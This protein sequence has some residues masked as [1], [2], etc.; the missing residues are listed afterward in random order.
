[1][2]NGKLWLDNFLHLLPRSIVFFLKVVLPPLFC[3]SV[4]GLLLCLSFCVYTCTWIYVF[5][6]F[7]RLL[8]V[9]Y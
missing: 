6:L 1:M 4:V 9:A 7:R 5:F 3:D 2:E 8:S